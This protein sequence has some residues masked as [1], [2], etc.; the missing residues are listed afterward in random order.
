MYACRSMDGI[1]CQTMV[2][3]SSRSMVYMSCRSMVVV[4]YRS[5]VDMSCRSMVYVCLCRLNVPNLQDLLR[6]AS[7]FPC[8]FWYCWTCT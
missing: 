5:M 4:A 2:V 6:I 1:S 7:E 3:A 8:C